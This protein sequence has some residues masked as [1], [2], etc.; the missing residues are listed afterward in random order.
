M[1]LSIKGTEADRLARKLAAT[2]GETLTEAI[3]VALRE[4]LER[5]HDRPAG[6]MESRL[7][8]LQSDAAALP[9][10]DDRS[11]EEII[12]YDSAGLPR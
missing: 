9:V 3:E 6:Q 11:P 8:R 7:R 1:A 10:R 5:T 12:G 2:T 4:R